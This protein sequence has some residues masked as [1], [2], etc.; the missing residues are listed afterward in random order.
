[1]P[2]AIKRHAALVP[3]VFVVFQQ[4]RL[5]PSETVGEVKRRLHLSVIRGDQRKSGSVIASLAEGK[6]MATA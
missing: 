5:V 3:L 2:Q 4:L 1:M 6:I